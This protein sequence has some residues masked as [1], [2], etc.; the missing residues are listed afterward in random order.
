MQLRLN[1]REKALALATAV[2]LLGI[3][4]FQFIYEPKKRGVVTLQGELNSLDS[5]IS[6]MMKSMEGVEKLRDDIPKLERALA[7]WRSKKQGKGDV[8]HFLNH[9]ARESKK[10][11]ITLSTI[12]PEEQD[13]G[14][15]KPESPSLLYK[16]IRIDLRFQANYFT[17]SSY[18][19]GL[20]ES[21]F[22]LT[23]NRLHIEGEGDQ[24]QPGNLAVQMR[25]VIYLFSSPNDG[26]KRGGIS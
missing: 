22:Y 25:L 18:L 4:L 16:R 17:L 7:F 1:K 10:L 20:E 23:L 6:E 11:G 21:P 8:A 3:V 2:F 12:K 26:S 13:Y 14:S 19:K 15:R 9:L 5:K 24:D